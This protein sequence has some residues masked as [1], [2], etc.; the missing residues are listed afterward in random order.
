MK[1]IEDYDYE[2]TITLCHSLERDVRWHRAD[3]VIYQVQWA[4]LEYSFIQATSIAP[5][6]V[7][8]YPDAP[9]GPYV[10][11][12]A[13]VEPM[14]LRTRG[15]DSTNASPTP[16]NMFGD[17]KIATPIVKRY[18]PLFPSVIVT[19]EISTTPITILNSILIIV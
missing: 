7:Y 4:Q 11:A 6:Q 17:F 8:Y 3:K 12:R 9:Q 13:G 5:L 14:T 19:Q 10:A 16:K 2:I 1:K 18:F 15:V